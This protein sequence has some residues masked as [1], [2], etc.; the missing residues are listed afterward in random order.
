MSFSEAFEKVL[1]RQIAKK[2]PCAARS[3]SPLMVQEVEIADEVAWS[4]QASK[5]GLDQTGSKNNLAGIVSR[6]ISSLV[7]EVKAVGGG[8]TALRIRLLPELRMSS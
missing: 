1:S 5:T 4:Q 8:I 7:S 3:V 2:M 6:G